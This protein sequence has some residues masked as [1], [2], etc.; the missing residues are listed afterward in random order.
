MNRLWDAAI[1][2]AGIAG[3]SLAKAL[4]D[5]GW[6]TMLLDRRSFPR[7]KVCGEFLSP[8]SQRMLHTLGL[9]ERVQALRPVA[10]E[11]IR[12]I[13]GNGAKLD[14]ELSGTAIGISRYRLDAALHEAAVEASAFVQTAATVTAVHRDGDGYLVET[15][16]QGEHSVIRARAVIAAWGASRR[17]DLP[18]IK[19]AF[20]SPGRT[21]LGVKSHFT[22][23]DPEPVVE[24]YLFPGGYMGICPVGD[25]IVNVA[26]LLDP[27]M[28]GGGAR[29]GA[30]LQLI[31]AAAR[32]NPALCRKLE[33]AMAI[34]GTQAAVAPVVLAR[35]L[36]AWDELPLIGDAAMM[37]PPLC[38]DGMS[39]ALR[40]ALLCADFADGYLRGSLP[41]A[42]WER[43]YSL[44]LH[45]EM[46]GPLRWGRFL[47]WLFGRPKLA[48]QLLGITRR[49][50]GLTE[51]LVRSTRLKEAER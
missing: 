25:G 15:K 27:M 21:M 19:A 17:P 7:H 33:G 16:R 50:P 38:G 10:I 13:A 40:S 32:G 47:Q 41:L 11:R 37:L 29:E 2:G 5:K 26:A 49:M 14:I 6:E 31:D 24:L 3:G 8:E 20:R 9:S 48:A 12:L 43:E 46:N 4:A 36:L 18:G 30:V 42:S 23:I 35:N 45:K 22:G 39:I 51:L 44:A 1:I 28:C 34:P